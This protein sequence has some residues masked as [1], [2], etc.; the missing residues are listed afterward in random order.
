[1]DKIVL[2]KT[3]NERLNLSLISNEWMDR[4]TGG[5]SQGR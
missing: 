3:E 1:M 2:M 4:W 5:Y